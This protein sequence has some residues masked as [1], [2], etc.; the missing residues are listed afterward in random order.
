[1]GRFGCVALSVAIIWLAG[2]GGAGESGNGNVDPDG[3]SLADNIHTSDL[4]PSETSDGKPMG[5]MEGKDEEQRASDDTRETVEPVCQ[6]G[7]RS[8]LGIREVA[9]CQGGN[10]VQVASCPETH[11]CTA[12]TCVKLEPC[13]PGHIDGC[14]SLA[15]L[16]Q[17]N[18]DGTAYVPIPCP[19]QE[20]CILGQCIDPVCFPGQSMCL[21]GTT[22][23]SCLD[24][25]TAWAEPAP[26]EAGLSC[27]GGKCLS[28]CLTDP[29]YNNSYIGCEYWSVDLDNYHDLG[30]LG[31]AHPD[32]VPH[33]VVLADPG[34][35][36]GPATVSFTVVM[37]DISFN[38]PE[39]V[40][41]PGE[42][43]V[44]EFPRM[45]IDGSGVFDRSIRIIS[46]RPVV[47]YQF[48]PLDFQAAYSDDSSLLIPAEMLGKEYLILSYPTS[49]IEAFPIF[50]MPSQHGYF[51]VIA[52]EEGETKVKV[53]V[54]ARTDP[55]NPNDPFMMPGQEY[56]FALQQ[57]Q[58]LNLQADGSKLSPIGDLSGSRVL[59]DKRVAVFSGHEEAVVESPMSGDC[60][61]AEHLEE[62]LFPLETWDKKYYCAKARSRGNGDYDLWRVQAGQDGVSVTTQPAI[63]GIN[64]ATLAKKGSWVEAFTNQS[65]IVEGTGPIQV[66]Q[67]LSSGTCTD[68]GIGDPALIMQVSDTQYRS[69]YIFAVP[70]DYSKDY[71]TVIRHSG[72]AV[73]LDGQTLANSAFTAFVDGAYEVG[74][75]E[76][77]DGPHSIVSDEPFG[78]YQYGFHGPA[79][80]GNPGGLNLIKTQ[81]SSE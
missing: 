81:G 43:K 17:C 7:T 42:V 2:C 11:V 54:T 68:Q 52:V 15:E 22:K 55:P 75:F 4:S 62:Q 48:N 65:F 60:C 44:V 61:C 40:V 21:D 70:K 49:P 3:V 41:Q 33:G 69:N 79:S 80:Y 6:H 58:V 71:I 14:Y 37:T 1:M 29:K 78:L 51:T 35:S 34:D 9:E 36:L 57:F 31:S 26:C 67:Y 10:W 50:S 20:K 23:Q 24:D 39:V 38:Q 73:V 16:R 27:V 5:D 53:W 46:N 66:A 59:A 47:A 8:C 32:E 74:Y 56:E 63:P 18:G 25:G 76:L 19:A 45:D 72:V 77:Q 13:T 64:G 30:L 12:G 28:Q